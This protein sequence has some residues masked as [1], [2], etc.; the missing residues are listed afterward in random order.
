MAVIDTSSID[1]E[2]LRITNL[3]TEFSEQLSSNHNITIA[4][5]QITTGVKSQAT[6]QQTGFVLRRFNQ[7]KPQELY[8]AELDRMNTT[9]AAENYALMN[10]NKQLNALIKEY[11]QTLENVMATFR[12]RANDVQQRELSI[13]REYEQKLL[14]RETEELARSLSSSTTLSMSIARLGK[15]LRTI[16]RTVHG[17]DPDSMPSQDSS[18]LDPATSSPRTAPYQMNSLEAIEG[19]IDSE[20]DR[21]L[22]AAEWSLE[23]ESELARLEEENEH[24][25]R[26]LA[27]HAG[28]KATN[29]TTGSS[30]LAELPKL[31]SIPK[32]QAR[33][34]HTQLGGRDVGPYG[35][36]KKFS[37]SN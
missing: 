24:L 7:D 37:E 3:L 28:I 31:T 23:R 27:E 36:Y 12:T 20:T 2:I 8:D 17:E 4:V 6:H 9:I 15:L 21:Q 34:L 16:M 19:P 32:V 29:G 5:K 14:I 13:V 1:A 25:K 33:T 11:E 26:L 10:D 30:K 35:T 18:A 22:A